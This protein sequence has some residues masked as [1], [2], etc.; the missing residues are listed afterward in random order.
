MAAVVAAVGLL[1]AGWGGTAVAATTPITTGAGLD[2]GVKESWRNYIGV[3]GTTLSDGVT[4]N[5]DGTFHFPVTG[6]SYDDATR[7]TTVQ[8]GGTVVFLGH[9]DRPDYGRPC[10]LDMTMVSPRVEITEDGAFLY[11]RM[12]SRPIEGGE[13]RDLPDV[14]VAS[15]DTE[16]A[17]PVLAGGTTSWSDL[18]AR[19]TLEGSEVFT[20]TV[21][22]VID[23]V[24][25]GYDGPGGRPAGE[26]WANPA[27]PVYHFD[28]LTEA[29]AAERPRFTHPGRNADEL[30]GV[31][32]GPVAISV[33]DRRTFAVVP[34]SYDDSFKGAFGS[35]A[36][37]PATGT[38]FYGQSGTNM[39]LSVRTWNGTAWTVTTVPGTA[40]AADSSIGGGAWDQ[41][42]RRY[43]VSR[44]VGGDSQLW[45]V[46]QEGGAWVGSSLGSVR[47]ANSLP[48]PLI[49]TLVTTP[50]GDPNSSPSVI[51]GA[52]F[53]QVQ[54]L[55]I[56]ANGIVAEPLAQAPGVTATQLVRVQNGVY[57]VGADTV[58]YIPINGSF[59]WFTLGNAGP[60]IPVP[61]ASGL[62]TL[63]PG[64]VTSD[65]ARDTLFVPSHGLTKVMR[66]EAGTLRH[67]FPLPGGERLL[68]GDSF[69]PGT[70]SDGRLVRTSDSGPRPADALAYDA[71]TPSFTTQPHDTAVALPAGT[72]SADATL[73]AAVAGDP[74]PAVR[75]QSRV[76]G[77]TNWADLSAADGV[78]GQ[79]TTTLTIHAGAG[80]SGR[81]YRAIASSSAGE[82]ASERVL[83]D[84]KTPP[85]ISVQPDSVSL[86]ESA[87]AALFKVFPTANPDPTVH[88]QQRIGGFWREIDADSGDFEVDGGFLT[89]TDP[90]A[91][92]SGTQ[93]RARIVNEVGTTF[94]RVVTLTVAPALTEPVTFGGGYVDWGFA[95]RWRCYVVGNIARGAI[96]PSGGV[97]RNP[98]TLATGG[99][100]NGR[101]AG[102]ETLR[103]PV[104]GGSYDPASGRLEVSL[105]GAVRFW[106][107]D[108]HVPG[109]TTPQLDTR[110]SG[111]RMVVENGVGTLYTDA[112][113]ATMDSP[114]PRTYSQVA[115]V[116]ADFGGVSPARTANGLAW[117]GV[118]TAL[119]EEGAA[120]FGSYARGEAFDPISFDLAFGEP[121]RDPEPEEP[122]EPQEPQQPQPPAPQPSPDP[123][124]PQPSPDPAPQ[125]RPAPTVG[126]ATF[127]VPKAVQR[128]GAKRIATVATVAC[129]AGAACSLKAPKVVGV[130]IGGKRYSARVVAPQRI[131]AG[132]RA[133]LRVRLT[134]AAVKRLAG[135]R[136]TVRV[137]VTVT[138]GSVATKRTVS[139]TL[140]GAPART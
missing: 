133:A 54:R 102:S 2:W 131:A 122:Q 42:G 129:P 59:G 62:S 41:A 11:A 108:Y 51:M 80:H 8:F 12:A 99:L 48:A 106:G 110:F 27:E 103:F 38:V 71:T 17:T 123:A 90:T 29:A 76:P 36:T 55:S 84:V 79:D 109:D 140:R 77:Q 69:L 28:A 9:C 97:T 132:K 3:G 126:R 52:W 101:N 118:P 47:L 61:A 116:S 34:G 88:W 94:S 83:L 18:P 16:D 124:P 21:G 24:S 136:A 130:R 121:G 134:K 100:C 85:A 73:S 113:G 119:T 127:A 14:R 98:G 30:V 37:D 63:D 13:I 22:T 128:V 112:V 78:A 92:M 32:L 20:Y 50:N 6:G 115:L 45:S 44:V 91:A 31:H 53:G 64:L 70:T 139:V 104:R 74:A 35:V 19:M 46:R 138:S 96:E 75:W 111:L 15:L 58:R 1:V 72:P 10:A 7:T 39:S 43:L 86:V 87:G 49:Q 95:E 82:V 23:P 5:A 107:H 4:R 66:I 105:N 125:P 33:V 57:A 137:V 60:A 67:T 93:F 25:F 89:V 40:I 117:A 65:R 114:T 81:Q 68:Y 26:S 56:A 135:R 120:V